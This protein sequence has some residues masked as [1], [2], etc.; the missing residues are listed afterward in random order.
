MID[1]LSYLPHMNTV[2]I[3]EPLSAPTMG[4]LMVLSTLQ[5]QAPYMSPIYSSAASQIGQKAFTD[6]GGKSFKDRLMSGMESKGKSIAHSIG[7]TDGE[8]GVTL[9][10]LRVIRARQIN[11]NGPKI[12]SIR[13]SLTATPTDGT[14]VF[15]YEW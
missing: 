1:S 7:I 11:L 15:K 3:Q 14:M 12:Y 5:Y 13:T 6:M 10:T 8:L 2:P 4:L 9:G